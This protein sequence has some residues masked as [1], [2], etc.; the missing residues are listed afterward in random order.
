M[1]RS[2]RF[3]SISFLLFTFILSSFTLTAQRD[4]HW[5]TYGIGFSIPGS[6]Q[7][8]ANSAAGFE[9]SNNDIYLG[10]F[11][12][13]DE[14]IDSDHLYNSTIEIATELQY[15]SIEDGG[16]LEIDDFE[17]YY[18]IGQ[19]DGISA[20]VVTLLDT[21]SETNVFVVVAFADGFDSVAANIVE[22]FYAY[23]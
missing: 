4:Y 12:F 9:A 6:M 8:D 13:D 18:V 2:T 14:N 1:K 20:L 19:K 3:L 5:D 15:D 10:I 23:D 16:E 17:G 7:I 22:S 21:E 11:P